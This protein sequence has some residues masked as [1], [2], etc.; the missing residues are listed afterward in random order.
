MLRFDVPSVPANVIRFEAFI[1]FVVCWL[2][3]FVTPWLLALLAV[4]GLVR[5]FIGHHRCPSHLVWKKALSSR[6]WQGP[7]ENAGAKM[8]ANK[9]LLLASGAGLALFIA[10]SGLWIVPTIALIIFSFMEWAFK[11]CAACW[12]YALWYQ[13]FPPGDTGQPEA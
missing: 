8:F 3:L 1:T 9:I 10:N 11:F 7:M 5:G 13:R 6:G 2:A 4:Q 12:V